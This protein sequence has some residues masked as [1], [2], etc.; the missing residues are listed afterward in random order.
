[1]I[2]DKNKKQFVFGKTDEVGRVVRD[3]EDKN[4]NGKKGKVAKEMLKRWEKK[5]MI[6]L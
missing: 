3:K 6:K 5:N 4:K 2:W 1:M